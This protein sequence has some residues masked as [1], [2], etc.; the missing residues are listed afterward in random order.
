VKLRVEVRLRASI[1]TKVVV[2]GLDAA[3][4]VRRRKMTGGGWAGVKLLHL[5]LDQ[6]ASH[7]PPL[8]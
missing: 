7:L 2:S 1:R 3:G 8:V 6:M 5:W 4:E